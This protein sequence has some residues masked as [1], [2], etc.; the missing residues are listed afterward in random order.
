MTDE[1]TIQGVN[2]QMQQVQKK[3][4]TVPYT[5]GGA[6]VGAAAGWGA[7]ALYKGSGSSKSY[8]DLVKEANDKDKLE[9]TSKKDAV[10]KA[11]QELAEASKAVYEGTEKTELDNAI[12]AKNKAWQKLYDNKKSILENGNNTSSIESKNFKKFEVLESTKLPSTH[13]K[14]GKPFKGDELKNLYNRM[15]TEVEN[16]EKALKSNLD[17]G[18]RKDKHIY[19]GYTN[20]SGRHVNGLIE[21]NFNAASI[22]LAGKTEEQISQYFAEKEVGNWLKGK[23]YSPQYQRVFDI[24]NKYYPEPKDLTDEQYLSIGRELEKGE[25]SDGLIPKSVTV[26]NEKGRS[27][28]KE[29]YYDEK[30][31]TQLFENEKNRIKELRITAADKLF[32]E[33]Q[34]SVLIKNQIAN[35]PD[36]VGAEIPEH[37]AKETGYFTAGTAGAADSFDMKTIIA[38]GKGSKTWTN[39]KITKQGYASDIQ[40]ILD[41]INTAEASHSTVVMPDARNLNGVYNVTITS[42]DTAEQAMDKVKKAL[43]EAESR[44]TAYKR[45]SKQEKDLV[46][47]LQNAIKNNPIVEEYDK[48]IADT[49]TNDKRLNNAKAQL[50]E[51]FPKI[52]GENTHSTLSADEIKKQATEFADNN[53]DKNLTQKVE[54]LQKAYDKIAAEKGKVNETAKK[55]A[56]EAVEKAKG[57]LDKLVADLNGKVK[58]MSGTAKA[59]VIGG[60]A[61]AGALIGLSMSNKSKNV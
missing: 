41:A 22:D 4:N 24:A 5:L 59:L 40:K 2:P 46:E 43:K 33:T 21:K 29:I 13:P 10:T 37:I 57:E 20:S 42:S 53:L 52:F 3:N 51:F 54:D 23:K 50:A 38:E 49:I 34:K 9:L 47:Q 31:A 44:Q 32:E 17:S 26:K 25:K 48:K 6:A 15:T 61:A 16:A 55:T 28:V 30:E 1:L 19:T 27:I 45:Y 58:G 14:S 39:G 56:Q 8:E 7:T 60:V 18:L 12:Q 35:L 36:K 11:E